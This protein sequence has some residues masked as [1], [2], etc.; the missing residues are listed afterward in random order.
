LSEGIT[1]SREIERLMEWE[2]GL[3]WLGAI[4][5]VNHASLNEFRVPVPKV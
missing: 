3:M 5:P 4:E 2:P 1:S